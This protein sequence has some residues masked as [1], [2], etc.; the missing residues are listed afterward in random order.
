[1]DGHEELLRAAKDAINAL[2]SDTSVPQSTTRASLEELQDEIESAL[3]SLED[4]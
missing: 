2:F 4:C 3:D 1:M